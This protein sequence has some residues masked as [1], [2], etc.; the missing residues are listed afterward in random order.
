MTGKT[1]ITSPVT[2]ER[3]AHDQLRARLDATINGRTIEVVLTLTHRGQV[4]D[5]QAHGEK[6]F[7]AG[8]TGD[9]ELDRAVRDAVRA[10]F[11]QAR[12]AAVVLELNRAIDWRGKGAR[13]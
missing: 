7:E 6:T 13:R 11:V 3:G 9:S 12:N 5:L 1:A 8:S 10:T 4:L 2:L